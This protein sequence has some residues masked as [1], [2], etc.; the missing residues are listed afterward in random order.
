M[1]E[2]NRRVSR[3]LQTSKH[4]PYLHA[5]LIPARRRFP[6]GYAVFAGSVMRTQESLRGDLPHF[7]QG[8]PHGRQRGILKRS[9]LNIVKA[10]HRNILRHAAPRFAQRLDGADGGSVVERKKRRERFSA[11]KSAFASPHIRAVARTILLRAARSVA[12]QR[13]CQIPWPPRAPLPSALRYRN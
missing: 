11:A 12:P 1:A 10:N 7:P 2:D 3:V 9:A 8:L 13:R 5:Q 6:L 4:E